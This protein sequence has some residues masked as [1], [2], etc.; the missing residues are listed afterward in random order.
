MRKVLDPPHGFSFLVWCGVVWTCHLVFVIFREKQ[1][2]DSALVIPV[3]TP[4]PTVT[5][6]VNI[7]HCNLKTNTSRLR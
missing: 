4:R 6:R 1:T 3:P 5:L 7:V 2:N